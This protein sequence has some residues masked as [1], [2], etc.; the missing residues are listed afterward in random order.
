[1]KRK[2][3]HV[4]TGVSI[5]AGLFFLI[6]SCIVLF[7]VLLNIIFAILAAFERPEEYMGFLIAF[8]L[9]EY[10]AACCGDEHITDKQLLC[11]YIL[12]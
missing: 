3:R 5:L 7:S 6:G 11:S 8:I 9:F 1:M 10:P 12:G 2:G 4:P